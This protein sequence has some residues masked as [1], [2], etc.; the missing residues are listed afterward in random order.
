MTTQMQW[1]FEMK[2]ERKNL[3]FGL[4]MQLTLDV[5]GKDV[6]KR[7]KVYIRFWSPK[8]GLS[9]LSPKNDFFYKRSSLEICKSENL[10]LKWN[11]QWI[12][13]TRKYEKD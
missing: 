10:G 8:Q 1:K 6:R 3:K 9:T 4:E 11:K 12:L 2:K 7:L 13:Q 5:V